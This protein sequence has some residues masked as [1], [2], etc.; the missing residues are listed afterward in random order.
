MSWDNSR[1]T[2]EKG[3]GWAWQQLRRRVLDRD[4]GRCVLCGRPAS[5]ADHVVGRAEAE[6]LGWPHERIEAL[7]NLRS[8]CGPHHLKVTARQGNRR[9]RGWGPSKR[10]PERHPGML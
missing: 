10:P 1:T 3:Y 9:G 8:L 7:D 5:D 4:G 6:R 2:T